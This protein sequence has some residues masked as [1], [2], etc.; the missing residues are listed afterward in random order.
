MVIK[1]II[2]TPQFL[3][4]K[5]NFDF[6]EQS[7]RISDVNWLFEPDGKYHK[8]RVGFHSVQFKDQD[9]WRKHKIK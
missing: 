1:T 6:T 2:R 5:Y 7:G 4:S 8:G 9:D 3:G